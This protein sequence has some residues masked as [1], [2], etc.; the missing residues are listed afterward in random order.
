M[1]KTPDKQNE[2]LELYKLHA[3]LEDRGRQRR[4]DASRLY[5]S[6][7]TGVFVF[8][9]AVVRFGEGSTHGSLIIILGALGLYLSLCWIYTMKDYQLMQGIKIDNLNKMEENFPFQAF[10]EENKFAEKYLSGKKL[11]RMTGYEFL[12]RIFFLFSGIILFF[13]VYEIL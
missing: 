3:E 7:A 8:C 6:L 11:I 12:P 9:A 2:M 13:G 5:V 1:E 10:Q 4:E